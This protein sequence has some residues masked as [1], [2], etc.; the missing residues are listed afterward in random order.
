MK[1]YFD[2]RMLAIT[3]IAFT[4]CIP[5]MMT[6][7]TLSIWLKEY[8]LSYSAIGLF[9]LLHIPYGIKFLWAPLLDSYNV[10]LLTRWMGHRR[11]WLFVTQLGIL[12]S[13]FIMSRFSPIEDTEIFAFF[14]FLSTIFGAS[15]HI[16]LLAYQIETMPENSWGTGEATSV[17]GFRLSMMATGAG[18]LYL[19]TYTTWQNV[20]AIYSSLLILGISILFII[21]EPASRRKKAHTLK[22]TF[23][24]PFQDFFIN[25]SG[26]SVLIFMM[27]FRLPDSLLSTMPNLFYLSVGFT[28]VDIANASKIFG[29][30]V[31]I[32]GGFIGAWILNRGGYRKTLF[33]GGLAHGLSMLTFLILQWQGNSLPWLYG[34]IAVE[35]LTSGISLTA[36]FTYQ[37]ISCRQEYA[38][39]QLALMTATASI[40][41]T[42]IGSVS[43]FAVDTLGWSGFFVLVTLAMI[44]GLLWISK[45]P[46]DNQLRKIKPLDALQDA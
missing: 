32:L 37:M 1:V 7:S 26:L 27:V 40:A 4:N 21:P 15:Q 28:K 35:H 11:A 42:V 10:P 2:R 17:L 9:A 45:L 5:L 16:L 44:P 13:L 18:A 38:A 46:K 19:A 20:Y 34:V 8:G 22:E 41:H 14:G 23:Y 24:E 3:V 36:F 30:A 12:L 43:G 31:T 39:S 29:L 33:W 6:S 25:H